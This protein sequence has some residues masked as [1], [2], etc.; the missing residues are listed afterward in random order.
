MADSAP[1]SE[2]KLDILFVTSD[3]FPPFR[4]AAKSVFAE[5]LAARGHRIDWLIQAAEPTSRAG[6]QPFKGG[7]A[8]VAPTNAG[9]T[10]LARLKRH[11]ADAWNDFRVFGL[12]RRRRYSLVQI[13]DKYFG[14]LVA[15]AAAKLHGVPV[16]YWLAYPHGEASLYAARSGVARYRWLYRWRG[17]LQRFVLYRIIMP[18]CTH[19]FVQSEQ[20]R[21]DVAGEGIPLELM[22]AVPSSLNLRDI[23]A[24]AGAGEDEP[25]GPPTVVYLGTLLRERQLDF[26]VRAHA[27]VVSALPDAQ[28]VFVG[29]GWMPDD[30]Q[31][32]RREAERLGLGGNVTITGWLPMRD[33]W[34]HV[35]RAAL[36][37]SP[38][39]PVP[40][41]RSTS[42]TKLIEYMALGKA[43]VANDH[44]EQ[45]DV[46]RASGAGLVCAWDEQEFAA[47]IVELLRD[48]ERCKSMGAAGRR[49][50][51]EHRTHWA[52]VD[53]VA[54][55]YRQHLR[56][57]PKPPKPRAFA[58][59]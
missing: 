12:L 9:N 34:R 11:L 51:A 32:L 2:Q 38:Y 41:L 46:L 29:S 3:L 35:R 13:K 48:P 8:Y 31:L 19:V 22:T 40:I 57:P 36:C 27:R 15:I 16:F 25:S 20:M 21:R 55:R 54:G 47:A 59:V 53:L 52:M 43:V 42:P 33:A 28:L 14:A 58:R 7:V 4:P 50:V 56:E 49:Y 24:L 18:A 45:A 37:V 23:D 39:L 26:I 17:A 5:G 10:R 44:P 6:E 30:E 1:R